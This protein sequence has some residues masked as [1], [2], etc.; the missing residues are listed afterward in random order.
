[1][2]QR[3]QCRRNWHW[4]A[5]QQRILLSVENER[6]TKS[7]LIAVDLGVDGS[8]RQ[9]LGYDMDAGIEVRIDGV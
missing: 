3:R 6:T 9:N 5:L 8:P 1:M 2:K 7:R 4:Q